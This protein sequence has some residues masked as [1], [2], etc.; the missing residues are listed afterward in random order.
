MHVSAS[1]NSLTGAQPA[2][3]H[4]KQQSGAVGTD[5]VCGGVIAPHGC[6]AHYNPSD[7]S[8]N[9]NFRLSSQSLKYFPC[10]PSQVCIP[11]IL[12]N[13]HFLKLWKRRPATRKDFPRFSQSVRD[14]A[15]VCVCV[16]WQRPEG[17]RKK[18][19]RQNLEEMTVVATAQWRPPQH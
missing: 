13:P 1:V 7:R 4:T 10:G 6:W 2:C 9:S 8:C 11:P 16:F 12:P 3:S 17:Q 14:R 15:K 5:T 19:M 18:G